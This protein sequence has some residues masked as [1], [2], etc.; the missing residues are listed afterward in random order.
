MA[1]VSL[2]EADPVVPED[3]ER[4]IFE[5]AAFMNPELMSSLL[6]VARRVK[7]WIEPILYRALYN[8]S[9]ACGTFYS[10]PLIYVLRVRPATFFREHV[11][12]VWLTGHDT[13]LEIL[14]LIS[15]CAGTTDLKISFPTSARTLLA[16]AAAMPLQRLAG[17]LP[18]LL[19]P[20]APALAHRAFARLTHLY[21]AGAAHDAGWAAWAGAGLA[22]MPA[23]THF[24]FRH[25]AVPDQVAHGALLN[26]PALRVLALLHATR[27][28]LED[29]R[30][31]RAWLV[32]DA[33]FVMLV[34][35]DD[36]ADWVAGARGGEDFWDAA[37]AVV[38]SR[39]QVD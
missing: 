35:P 13:D 14:Q 38:R 30:P 16:L 21:F 9:A 17:Y 36:D 10:P 23:L 5:L 26:C 28:E 27:D 6:R 11:R 4:H 33:R 34:V 1:P 2:S 15:V 20:P 12:H 8:G 39:P 24:A 7:I 3:V 32:A 37:D 25:R 31:L 22:Q 29:A 18:Y 19:E